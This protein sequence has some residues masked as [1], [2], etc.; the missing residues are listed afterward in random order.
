MAQ[1]KV[2]K[3][4]K[5]QLKRKYLSASKSATKESTNKESEFKT[6]LLQCSEKGFQKAFFVEKMGKDY[7]SGVMSKL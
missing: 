5:E 2:M 4:F 7:I 6:H 3:S 1:I